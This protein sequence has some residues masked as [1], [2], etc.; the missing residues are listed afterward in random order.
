MRA[1]GHERYRER[2]QNGQVNGITQL[3]DINLKEVERKL[4]NQIKF[5][6][7]KLNTEAS[8]EELER[9]DDILE[10]FSQR[11]DTS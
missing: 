5:F 7:R 2:K 6:Y 10:K 11:I 8:S 9:L 3:K 4:R 1:E